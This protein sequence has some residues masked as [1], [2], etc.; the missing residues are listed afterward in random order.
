MSDNKNTISLLYQLK[1]SRGDKYKEL[2]KEFNNNEKI[3]I[4]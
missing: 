3:S 4:F 1:Y 2:I